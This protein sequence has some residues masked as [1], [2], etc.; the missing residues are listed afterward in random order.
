M[1]VMHG[2]SLGRSAQADL[3]AG[4]DYVLML[5]TSGSAV[6]SQVNELRQLFDEFMA[7][8]QQATP[9]DYLALAHKI[10]DIMQ[11]IANVPGMHA[12]GVEVS[13]ELLA[14][15]SMLLAMPGDAADLVS[16]GQAIMA[17]ESQVLE[18]YNELR[19]IQQV[20]TDVASDDAK[21]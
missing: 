4:R 18:V 3:Q 19:R 2:D 11:R 17:F 1:L 14:Y 10:E 8:G 5:G 9:G 6:T 13:Q 15:A 16:L 7:S 20:L 12:G 21:C